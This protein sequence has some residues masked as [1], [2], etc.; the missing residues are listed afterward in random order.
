[1]LNIALISEHASP[2]AAAGSIDSGGQN[3]YVAQL[4]RQLARL[5]HRVDVFTRRD[6]LL[7]RTIVEWHP[8]V[9]IIHVPAGP[10]WYVAKEQLLP[11]MD[12]FGRFI[13]R[14]ARQQSTAYDVLHANFFMSGIAAQYCHDVL[15]IPFVITFHALGQVRRLCQGSAD[16]FPPSR[17]IIEAQLMQSA[18]RII[19][20]CEQDRD[21]MRTLYGAPPRRI[22][23]VPCGFDP[24]EFRPV[25]V[26][27]RARL[28]LDPHAFTLLQLG[29]MVPRKGIDNVIAALGIL[30]HEH[31]I[32]ARLVVVGGNTPEPDPVATPEIGRLQKLA[33]ETG[34]REQVRFVGQVARERLRYYY[35]AS[36]VFVTTPWYEPFGITPLEAMA[37][38]RPVVGANVGG[39]KSTVV[40]GKTGFLVPPKE[41][42]ALA[43]K[44]AV[45]ARD[46]K[47]GAQMG[48]AGLRRVRSHYTWQQVAE[49]IS[50]IYA[51]ACAQNRRQADR[52]VANA[53]GA[54]MAH[55]SRIATF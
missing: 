30:R 12:A 7:Q 8:N 36:D 2:L 46:P 25:T 44:L 51:V 41:P 42:A 10:A 33:S 11:Y 29:R 3:I 38:A 9:R 14:F 21:D 5:G 22:D 20:E 34:V 50:E 18:G 23:I 27:A 52:P 28:G 31:A 53:A 47:L 6:S 17:S 55:S 37:C 39:I 4:A 15:G 48:Q 19:A 35:T 43:A 32:D 16:G 40:D 45:L 26:D 1:M 54:A 49:Q 24:Q 13:V